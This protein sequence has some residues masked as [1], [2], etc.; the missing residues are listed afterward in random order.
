[1]LK[2]Q[3]YFALIFMM[4]FPT[5]ILCQA[6]TGGD[7]SAKVQ[8]PETYLTYAFLRQ[9]W[10]TVGRAWLFRHSWEKWNEAAQKWEIA[11]TWPLASQAAQEAYYIEYAARGAVNMGLVCHDLRLLDELAQF[12]IVY[13]NRF[14]TLDEMRRQKSLDTELLKK[15]GDD[16]VRTLAWVEKSAGRDRM[17][18]CALC[19]AQFF[20]PL[21]RLMR[22]IALLPAAQRTLAMTSFVRLYTPLVVHEQLIRWLYEAEDDRFGAADLPKH[23]VEIYKAIA[24][25]VSRSKVSYQRAMLDVD[26][27]L[28]ADAAE[29]LGA[30]AIDPSLIALQPEE[31]SGLQQAV[32]AGVAEFQQKRRLLPDTKNFRSEVVGSAS[33]F[34]GDF[35]DHEDSAYSG[36]EGESFP[37]PANK[38]VRPDV[39]WDMSHAYR[40]PIFLRSL[41]DN[42]MAAGIDFPSDHDVQLVTNQVMYKVFNGNFDRPMFKN[43]FDGGNG[44]FRVGY[45]GR[46]FGYPPYQYCDSHNPQRPCLTLS[47]VQGWGLIASFN[48]DLLELSHALATLAWKDDPDTR[49]FKD[50]YY[51]YGGMSYSVRNPAGQP[52]YPIMLLMVLGDAPEKLRGCDAR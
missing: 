41:Y 33:Y 7:Q 30:N 9:A 13:A 25:S 1:M 40:I 3:K 2:S 19:N 35:A 14:T 38:S 29:I 36:Y 49:R 24:A 44:W 5:V 8:W 46:G 21:I 18:E 22:V 34:N 32:Q 43:Y 20:G 48:P 23:R 45:H 17:R 16:S 15:Q 31:K 50:Q 51:W 6:R 10:E 52:Q 4:L 28:I 26:L 47:E 39:S 42:K 11:P 12:Y 37:T 27:W